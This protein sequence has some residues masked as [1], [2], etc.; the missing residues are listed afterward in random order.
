MVKRSAQDLNTA[1]SILAR[2]A[3]RLEFAET[4]QIDIDNA[5]FI[6]ED[7]YE[8]MRECVLALMIARGFK[9]YS[10]EATVAFLNDYYLTEFGEKKVRAFDRYRI[11]RNDIMYRA[12]STNVDETKK[13]MGVAVDFVSITRQLFEK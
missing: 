8:V 2:A 6:F 7:V 5:P 4:Q 9:P 13:S 11:M 3:K 12:S 10:H 1:K